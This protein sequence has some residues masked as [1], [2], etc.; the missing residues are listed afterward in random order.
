MPT[1]TV[2]L[3]PP[4]KK[5]KNSKIDMLLLLILVVCSMVAFSV[6]FDD[7]CVTMLSATVILTGLLLLANMADSNQ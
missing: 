7:T 5:V 4:K 3:D 1:Y 6:Y 2:S